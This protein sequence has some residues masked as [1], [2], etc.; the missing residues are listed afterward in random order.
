[1]I[2]TGQWPLGQW[3][4][5]SS[6]KGHKKLLNAFQ[7]NALFKEIQMK[8]TQ[9]EYVSA[10]LLANVHKDLGT[11]LLWVWGITSPLT[12]YWWERLEGSHWQIFLQKSPWPNSSILRSL[13]DT[14]LNAAWFTAVLGKKKKKKTKCASRRWRNGLRT[15]QQ[16]THQWRKCL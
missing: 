6:R 15:A 11:W 9:R 16:L 10:A 3:P 1:M 2:R 13:S 5:A 14:G 7:K 4:E 12:R 8:T